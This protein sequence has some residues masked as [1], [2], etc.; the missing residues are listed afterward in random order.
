[1][2]ADPSSIHL[3]SLCRALK[4]LHQRGAILFRADALLGHLGARCVG[5]RPELEQPGNRLRRPDNI[6]ALEGLGKIIAWLG[7]DPPAENTGER[8]ARPVRL[9]GAKGMAGDTSTKDIRTPIA[10]IGRER[11]PR[12]FPKARIEQLPLPPLPPSH[13]VFL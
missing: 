1:M 6:E 11:I 4:E 7:C 13:D 2:A 3:L 12:R 8:R 5:R 10:G 9:L